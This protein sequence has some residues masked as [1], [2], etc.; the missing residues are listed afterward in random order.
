MA[1]S[2]GGPRVDWGDALAVPSFYDREEELASLSQWVV[3]ERCRVVSVLGLGGIGKSALV[4]SLMHQ[5]A[6]RFEVVIWR[7]LRDAPPAKRYWKTACRRL[8]P[9]RSPTCQPASTDA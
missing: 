9:S 1:Q 4:V 2:T 6:Q 8:P 7:S 3:Q 5:V